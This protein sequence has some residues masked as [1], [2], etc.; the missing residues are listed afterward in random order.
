MDQKN[1]LSV[2][3]APTNISK[4]VT[5]FS[6]TRNVNE[7]RALGMYEVAKF[8]FKRQMVEKGIGGDCSQISIGGVFLDVIRSG[9]S[10]SSVENHVYLMTRSVKIP[11]TEKYEKR[12][13]YSLT[14]D[15]VIFLAQKAKSVLE[16]ES[17]VIVY[18]GDEFQPYRNEKGMNVVIHK[19]KIPRQK[20]AKIIA[21]Y[22]FVTLPSG[23]KEAYYMVEEDWKR[24]A[25]YSDKQ[26]RGKGANV[27]YTS[28]PFGQIDSGFLKAKLIKHALKNKRKAAIVSENFIEEAEDIPHE[29]I[30][31]NTDL[32]LDIPDQEPITKTTH[33]I[34]GPVS[35]VVSGGVEFTTYE[36][37]LKHEE[38]KKEALP[39][40]TDVFVIP[41][42]TDE[43]ALDLNPDVPF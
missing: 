43:N 36:D 21:G 32:K 39:D 11:G 24:L 41:V 40:D 3:E 1:A 2:I 23:N 9:M 12:L 13:Y 4:F 25:G 34:D 33:T 7:E 31:G 38:E 22:I 8:D 18:E 15:G 26:N 35:G 10:F 6:K 16:V 20:D 42:P 19:P 30:T 14:P 27:L 17:P 5:L 29:E 37:H 28:G